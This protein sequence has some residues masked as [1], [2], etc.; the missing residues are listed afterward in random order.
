MTYDELLDVA[1]FCESIDL[2]VFARSDHYSFPRF[3][4]PHATDAFATLGG[5][6]RETSRIGLCVLV[7]PIT[8]RHPGVIAKTA[9][10][11]DEMSNGRMILGVGTGWMEEEHAAL[12]LPFPDSAERFA[13]LEESLAY[14]RAAFGKGDGGFE[15]DYYSLAAGEVRPAPTGDLPLVVGGG[16]PRR[17]PRLAGTFA[18]EYNVFM[19]HPD[20]V[21]PRVERARAAAVGAGRDPDALLV[22]MMGG[23]VTG[24]DEASYRRNL[25]RIAEAHP[26]GRTPDQ[27]EEGLR[28]RGLPVGPPDEARAALDTLA[29]VGVQRYYLQHLGP[30]DHGL[31]EGQFEVLRS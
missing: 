4:A 16:G 21:A 5:L 2:D 25:E 9:A 18:D 30:F 31:L 11:I 15:G 7:S 17:T 27:I 13:R 3:E 22:S 26:F 20:D 6:A 29:A 10:T 23:A 28:S 1:T 19:M 8:F 14:L 24:R 12:G